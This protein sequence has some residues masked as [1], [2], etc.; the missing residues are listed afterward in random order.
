MTALVPMPPRDGAR[1]FDLN[2]E[3]VLEHWP[4]A[5]ALR[6]FISNALD[7]QVLTGTAEPTVTS[8][9]DGTWTVRDF[10]R[11]LR[12]EHLTQNENQEKLRHPGVIGQF[13][14]GL[15]DALAVC[16]RKKV[17]VTLRSRH[18]DFTTAVLPKAGFVDAARGGGCSKRPKRCRDRGAARGR[19]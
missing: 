1:A 2:V 9:Q 18:G 4:V 6:E 7:E 15:K 13:G 17:K 3:K 16:D 14:I 12:Y 8:G 19:A 5:F 11:G 10:G